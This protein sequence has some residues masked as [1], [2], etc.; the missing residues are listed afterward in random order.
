MT[1]IMNRKH[2]CSVLD[3]GDVA[4]ATAITGRYGDRARF[5]WILIFLKVH[6]EEVIEQQ[7]EC[8]CCNDAVCKHFFIF[9]S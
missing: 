2:T 6:S 1:Y 4:T 3:F 7:M 8:D 9:L 5:D